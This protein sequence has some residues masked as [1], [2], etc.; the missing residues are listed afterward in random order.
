MAQTRPVRLT[1]VA[2]EA[3]VSIATASHA[4]TGKGRIPEATRARVREVAKRMGYRPNAAARSLAG[5]RT[6]LIAVAFSLSTALPVPLTDIDYFSRAI[7]AATAQALERDY[8][9]VIGPP[10]PQREV[11]SRIPF[12]GVV[13]FDPVEGDPVLAE[14]RQRNVP[15]VLSGRDPSGSTDICVDNDHVAGT[16][17]ALDHLSEQGGRRIALLV[18]ETHDAFSSDCIDA[19]RA[20]CSEQSCAPMIT[21]VSL[22]RMA[23][24]D[25]ADRALSVKE[26]P[27]A[28]YA[29]DELLGI[30]LLEAARRRGL[31]VPDDLLVVTAA[32]RQPT[33]A[34]IELTTLELDAAGTAAE[35][36]DVL[37]DLIEGRPP[38]ERMRFIPTRLVLGQSTNRRGT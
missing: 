5:G 4:L 38:T 35:A 36:V 15:M 32:D 37:I 12:D 27:D 6:R 3:G 23:R 20:W 34:P 25:E 7:R 13:V 33:G 19:Y 31:N 8:A 28:V 26:P 21:T 17:A 9:L 24:I 30:A 16:R 22:G 14:F 10:T 2:R 11:W 18:G 1:D 29:N